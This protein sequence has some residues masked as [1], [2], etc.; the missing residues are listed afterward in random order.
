MRAVA[1]L[2]LCAF[3][4]AE[5]APEEGRAQLLLY[6]R[7]SP[8][9]GFSVNKPFNVT[10]TVYNRGARHRVPSQPLGIAL[11]P[12]QAARVA[13]SPN[14]QPSTTAQTGHIAS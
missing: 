14:P 6:K 7:L 1:F 8:N 12:G 11:R 10:L 5:E 2:L 3:A 4:S 13:A 9:D